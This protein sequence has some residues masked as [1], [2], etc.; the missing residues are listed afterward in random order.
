MI[1]LLKIRGG[2][3]LGSVGDRGRWGCWWEI[4]VGIFVLVD[5]DACM[6]MRVN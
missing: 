1:G 3:V 5:W 2:E 4:G 6:G